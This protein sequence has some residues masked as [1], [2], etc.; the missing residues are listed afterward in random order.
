APAGEWMPWRGIAKVCVAGGAMAATAFSLRAYV[1]WVIAAVAAVAVYAIIL[2][3]IR[4][5]GPD[6]IRALAR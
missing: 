5:D 3:V 2:H 4:V 1:P 6:G